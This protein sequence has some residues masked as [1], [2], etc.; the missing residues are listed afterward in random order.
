MKARR[1]RGGVAFTPD[2][3][4]YGGEPGAVLL[5]KTLSRLIVFASLR[6]FATFPQ[7][8]ERGRK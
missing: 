8:P 6:R 3:D 5:T 7:E 2:F 1:N 4:G